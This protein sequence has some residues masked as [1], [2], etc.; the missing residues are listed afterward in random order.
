[1][2]FSRDW[3]SDVCS[4]D[5]Q[6]FGNILQ[7]KIVSKLSES[8]LGYLTK[9]ISASHRMQTLIDDV[10]TLSKLSNSNSIKEKID[11]NKLVKQIREDL[12][13]LIMEKK[14]VVKVGTLP[15]VMVVPGQIHQVF[16][17]LISNALK[18]N[19]KKKPVVT[20]EE[21]P[22][23]QRKARELGLQDGKYVYILVSDNG[24]GFENEY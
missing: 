11:L 12:E 9:M 6:A 8:E 7:S 23:S 2:R 17:N 5:L 15:S 24:I 1:T 20:I 14:A 22:L 18:F 3:S 4:S 13:I 16:Q 19:N 10:L 21:K